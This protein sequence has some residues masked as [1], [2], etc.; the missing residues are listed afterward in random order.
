MR[1]HQDAYA[2]NS[3]PVESREAAKAFYSLIE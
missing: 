1:C 2:A 3:L